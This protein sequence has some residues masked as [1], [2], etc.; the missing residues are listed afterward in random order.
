MS[1][2]KNVREDSPLTSDPEDIRKMDMSRKKKKTARAAL[3]FIIMSVLLVVLIF[4]GLV[5]RA[6]RER[7]GNL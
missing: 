7:G 3:S 6:D 4:P 1:E 5:H 2:E